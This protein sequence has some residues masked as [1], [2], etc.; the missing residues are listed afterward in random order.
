M[1]KIPPQKKHAKRR[2]PQQNRFASLPLSKYMIGQREDSK[3][4]YG[5][6]TQLPHR[7]VSKSHNPSRGRSHSGSYGKCLG[8]FSGDKLTPDYEYIYI[9]TFPE[10]CIALVSGLPTENTTPII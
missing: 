5:K 2:F 3:E 6:P 8:L 1:R 4:P 7:T 10:N 9:T